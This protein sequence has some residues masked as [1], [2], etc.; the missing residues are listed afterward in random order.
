MR[1]VTFRPSPWH[2]HL[3]PWSKNSSNSKSMHKSK[4]LLLR[5]HRYTFLPIWS[6]NATFIFSY[7]TQSILILLLDFLSSIRWE[8]NAS[9]PFLEGWF[10]PRRILNSSSCK[11]QEWRNWSKVKFVLSIFVHKGGMFPLTDNL[12]FT[13]LVSLPLRLISV[14]H[15]FLSNYVDLL[16][17]AL[18]F[19]LSPSSSSMTI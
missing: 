11:T 15:L 18:Y 12:G 4:K 17:L 3:R 7:T 6:K 19:F 2:P 8:I 10:T 1:K 9:G 16:V 5:W 14:S 13:W